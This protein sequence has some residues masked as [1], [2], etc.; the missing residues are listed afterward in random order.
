MSTTATCPAATPTASSM[1]P[2]E[3]D[4]PVGSALQ[5]LRAPVSAGELRRE[6]ADGGRVPRRSSRPRLPHPGAAC[7]AHRLRSRRRS[8]PS[9][10]PASSSP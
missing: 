2:A 3:S 5:A 9:P 4:H 8:G 1:R 7:R 6:D 10:P